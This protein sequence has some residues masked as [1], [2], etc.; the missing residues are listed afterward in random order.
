MKKEWENVFVYIKIRELARLKG[1]VTV[2][3]LINM[4]F[5]PRKANYY[6]EELKKRKILVEPFLIEGKRGKTGTPK[7]YLWS[8]VCENEL[9][10]D[11]RRALAELKDEEINFKNW[12]SFLLRNGKI[13]LTIIFGNSTRFYKKHPRT[14]PKLSDAIGIPELLSKPLFSSYGSDVIAALDD[15]VLYD[16]FFQKRLYTTDILTIGSPKVN[17]V[18]R[19]LNEHIVFRFNYQRKPLSDVDFVSYPMY[20]ISDP[21]VDEMHHIIGTGGAER[22]GLGVITICRSP[23]SEKNYAIYVAG[24]RAFVGQI[25]L[26]ILAGKW[27]GYKELSERP[28]GGVI[29]ASYDEDQIEYSKEVGPIKIFK[30]KSVSW[31]TPKYTVEEFKEKAKKQFLL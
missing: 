31:L 22:H 29:E 28:Y 17:M 5:K 1:Y 25:C 13:H 26:Q 9:I 10:E 3:D 8:N 18:S 4:G 21:F 27:D 23:F 16:S 2:K 14:Y 15:W 12:P 20:S 24:Y 7:A 6:F 19:I 11:M 30:V